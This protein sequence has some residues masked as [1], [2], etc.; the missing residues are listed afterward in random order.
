MSCRGGVDSD[1][2]RFS[3][4][5]IQRGVVD[6]IVD[7]S[8]NQ[9]DSL[10]FLASANGQNIKIMSATAS[11]V[12]N[13]LFSGFDLSNSANGRDMVLEVRNTGTGAVQ[14]IALLD[15]YSAANDGQWTAYLATLGYNG[16]IAA[17]LDTVTL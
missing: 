6:W 17:S 8:F 15:S 9:N 5:H 11:F 12:N 3:A 7:F 16:P 13:T 10:E 1:V 4:G 2:F 14:Y